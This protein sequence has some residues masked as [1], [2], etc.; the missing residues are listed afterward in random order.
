MLGDHGWWRLLVRVVRVRVHGES[1]VDGDLV[2]VRV[3]HVV[4]YWVGMVE[5]D[6]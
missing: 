1:G 6:G 5:D 4:R 2:G 3:L